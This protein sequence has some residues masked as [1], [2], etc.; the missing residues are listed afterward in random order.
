M[1]AY[2]NFSLVIEFYLLCEYTYAVDFIHTNSLKAYPF[3]FHG[4]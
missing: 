3:I 4:S 2:C 1:N